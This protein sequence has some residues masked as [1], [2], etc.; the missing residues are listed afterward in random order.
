[1][2]ISCTDPTLPSLIS[3]QTVDSCRS[4]STLKQTHAQILKSPAPSPDLSLTTK[5]VASYGRFGDLGSSISAFNRCG[6]APDA[7]LFNSLI[8]AHIFNSLF[9]SALRIYVRMVEDGIVPNRFTFPLLF[10]ACSSSFMISSG[11]QLHGHVVKSGLES[12]PFVAVGL[13][14]MY[15]KNGAIGS[16]RM[17]FDGMAERD[18]VA[19]NA[20]LTGYSQN[21]MP[22]EALGVYNGMREAG[23]DVD[24][25]AVASVIAACSQLRSIHQGKWVH[26]WVVKNGFEADVVVATALLDMYAS[27]GGLDLAIQ[28]F[29]EM[30][31]RDLIAW[32]CLIACCAQNGM[33]EDAF[34]LFVEMQWSGL[35]PNGSSLA[36]ILPAVGRFGALHLGKSCHG[37][38]VRNS[39]ELDEFVVTALM[40]V[41][42]KSGDLIVARRLFNIMRNKSVVAWSSMI[43]GYGTHGC[44][45]EALALFE[46]MQA[47]N[48]KPNYI[49]YIGVLSACAH[50]GFIDKGRDY[51]HRM[52]HNHGILPR[53]QHYTCMVD[54]FSRAGLLDEA[55]DLID[56]M[57]IEPSAGIWGA[58]L[59]GCRKHGHVGLGKYAAERLFELNSSDPGFYVLLS[60][61][62]A[63]AGMWADVRRVR[64]SMRERGLWKPAGW[65]SIEIGSKVHCFISGDM[66]H[67]DTNEIYKKLEEVME[68][69]G[70]AGY[71]PVTKVVLHDVEDDVK[72]NV[73]KCHSEKLAIAYGL[74]RTSVGQPIRIMKSLRTCEDCHVAAKLI[75]KVVC[76]EIVLRDAVRFHHIKDGVCTCGDYW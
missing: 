67:P 20:L 23:V 34:K 73:L 54:L 43:A 2:A 44:G 69:I 68:E 37:F 13:V 62:Y 75:S 55:M 1:M 48:I 60:N 52:V 22:A 19:W 63:A 39:L 4:L 50:G 10:K 18:V 17:V 58:L 27:S 66:A 14:D 49:T 8:Q 70:K 31:I 9:G 40:D 72:E 51:F 47:N 28:L 6:R 25:V 24:F 53:V 29:E 26:S 41:Y 65:S 5:L 45:D 12:N 76:R 59:G 46:K 15:M 16:A 3:S 33:I 7:F 42:A 56:A 32:N 35:K 36:G 71:V 21:G 61:I 64:S 57:P 38:I 11:V 30:V 74:I